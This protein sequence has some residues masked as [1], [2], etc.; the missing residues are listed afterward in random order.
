LSTFCSRRDDPMIKEKTA[1]SLRMRTFINVTSEGGRS[2]SDLV[3]RPWGPP[4]QQAR[5][6][7]LHFTR[8]HNLNTSACIHSLYKLNI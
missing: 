1:V 7:S 6:L 2:R 8:G 3:S 4:E 5:G